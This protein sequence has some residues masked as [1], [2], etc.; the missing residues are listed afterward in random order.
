MDNLKVEV[1]GTEKCGRGVFARENIKK[2]EIIAEFDGDIYDFTSPEWNDDI[3]NHAIQFED[4]RWR[5]SKGIARLINHSCE[6][7]CGIKDLFKIVT[8]RDIVAG[9][10]ILWDYSMT[11]RNKESDWHMDCRCGTKNCRK[12]IGSFDELP[13][14]IKEKYKGFVSE[15]LAK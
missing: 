8:M 10:E 11:E 3:E 14:S 9:E 7:N 12:R 1:R 13:K 6:P 15:W 5:D 2:G 4:R